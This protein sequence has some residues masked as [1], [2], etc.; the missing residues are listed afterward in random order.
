LQIAHFEAA[1]EDSVITDAAFASNILIS[2]SLAGALPNTGKL[3]EN[4]AAGINLAEPATEVEEITVTNIVSGDWQIREL[5][6]NEDGSAQFIELYYNGSDAV[7]L[8]GARLLACDN[9]N[10]GGCPQVCDDNSPNCALFDKFANSNT[11]ESGRRHVL[12]ATPSFE[13][14][15]GGGSIKT[16]EQELDANGNPASDADGNPAFKFKLLPSRGV[17]PDYEIPFNFLFAEGGHVELFL[18]GEG[19]A[20]AQFTY[21]KLPINGL[22][23]LH[24]G[25]ANVKEDPACSKYAAAAGQTAGA[26]QPLLVSRNFP[27]NSANEE[28]TVSNGHS[29]AIYDPATQILKIPAIYMVQTEAIPNPPEGMIWAS[30]F[31]NAETARLELLNV[32][33]RSQ[34]ADG[35]YAEFAQRGEYYDKALKIHRH[36]ISIPVVVVK[37]TEQLPEGDITSHKFYTAKLQWI[38][39]TDN[40]AQFK[41]FPGS[42]KVYPDID[43]HLEFDMPDCINDL[44]IA[45]NLPWP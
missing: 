20:A 4:A 34:P 41:L 17:K 31:L 45:Q 33:I 30:F 26:L 24:S 15:P 5:Y 1:G 6:S 43:I 21:S 39:G 18:A 40:P 2:P 25:D 8:K 7:S 13:A 29:H 32:G 11:A 38:E 10:P 28:G 42:G 16:E 36:V 37:E 23:S 22:C 3:L 44:R 12:F 19:S 9:S 14:L 27:V 35:H